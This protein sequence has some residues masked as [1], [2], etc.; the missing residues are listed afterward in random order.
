VLWSADPGRGT[1]AFEAIEADPGTVAVAADPAGRYGPSFR[2]ET[3]QELLAGQ[4]SC[5]SRGL[6]RPDG[7]VLRLDAAVEGET[8]YLGWRS[9]WDPMPSQRS[10][11]TVLFRLQG[12][13]AS[14]AGPVVL[15]TVGDGAL[16]LQLVS[17]DGAQRDIWTAPLALNTWNSFVLGFKLS[18]GNTD[19]WVEFWYNGAAQALSNGAT[20][21]PGTTLWGDR[22]DV[23]WGVD[24]SGTKHIDNGVAWLNHAQLGTSY[25][26]VAP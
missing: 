3:W 2:Y 17:S 26:A 14:G 20:R 10:T 22:A 12:S 8:F 5:E 23:R 6:R 25:A 13:G 24:R 18:R 1:R 4:G 21:Y 16:H 9:L 7:S 19:G 15:R 11:T